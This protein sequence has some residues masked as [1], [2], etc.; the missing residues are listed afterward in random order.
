MI[1]Y[2]IATFVQTLN[3]SWT[4]V[5]ELE[6]LA[7]QEGLLADWAQASWEALVEASVPFVSRQPRLAIYGDG[8]DVHSGSS[9]FSFPD[10]LPTHQVR[11]K[12]ANGTVL[13][14]LSGEP[15]PKVEDGYALD[16]FVSVSGNW[17]FDK[18]PFDHALVESNG[19]EHV[20]ALDGLKWEL[21]ELIDSARAL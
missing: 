5:G 9:R 14:R 19:H 8:A 12:P 7:K 2:A 3:A 20:V 15:I 18:P 10:D 13:D 4:E 6:K 16:R 11:C 17:Y 21:V 1:A